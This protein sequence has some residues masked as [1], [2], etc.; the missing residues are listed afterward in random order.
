[1]TA[2]AAAPPFPPPAWLCRTPAAQQRRPA[3]QPAAALEASPADLDRPPPPDHD[4][5]TAAPAASAGAHAATPASA[6]ARRPASVEHRQDPHP[7]PA[8]DGVP[9][10]RFYGIHGPGGGL[11]RTCLRGAT[12]PQTETLAPYRRSTP[13]TVIAGARRSCWS[14]WRRMRDLNP[15]GL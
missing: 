13:G 15:R 12:E 2:C 11:A 6:S 5:T 14:A 1:M 9:S 3:A 7:G 8:G 4:N 10:A